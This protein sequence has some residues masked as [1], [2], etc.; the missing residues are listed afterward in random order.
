MTV[1]VA[2]PKLAQRLR[3]EREG[4]PG[5]RYDEVWDGDY[6][7]M[8]VPNNEHQDL[9]FEVAVIFREV[10][11]AVG[12]GKAVG[13]INVSDREEGWSH[14]YRVPDAAVIL[15]GGRARNCETHW[16][17]GPDLVVEIL[18]PYDR[19]REKLPFYAEIGSREVLLIDRDPWALELYGLRDGGMVLVG[20]SDLENPAGLGSEVL[21][22]TFRLVAGEERPMIEVVHRDGQPRWLV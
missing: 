16:C 13:Q 21:P 10:V 12:L 4:A 14:N 9:A 11:R 8:P 15:N 5:S 7:I 2:D 1:I 19:A 18:S 6:V 3:A 22:L 20:R 17:G